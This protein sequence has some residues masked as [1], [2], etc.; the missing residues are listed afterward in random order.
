[1]SRQVGPAGATLFVA[2]KNLGDRV[3]ITERLE[4][5]MVGMPRSVQAGARWAF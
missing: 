5:I 3:Y 1:V 2:A 4:G